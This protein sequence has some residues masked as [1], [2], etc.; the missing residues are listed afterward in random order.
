MV[1]SPLGSRWL[2]S[3]SFC[4]FQVGWQG[5][6]PKPCIRG[7]PL[8][9]WVLIQPSFFSHHDATNVNCW[10]PLH[11]EPIFPPAAC[12]EENNGTHIRSLWKAST[13]HTYSSFR[14]KNYWLSL[15]AKKFISNC[16]HLNREKLSISPHTESVYSFFASFSTIRRP[17]PVLLLAY[18]RWISLILSFF[19]GGGL[20]LHFFPV[21]LINLFFANNV[22]HHGSDLMCMRSIQDPMV[23]IFFS[24]ALDLIL[25]VPWVN[26]KK[27]SPGTAL[28]SD[29]SCLCSPP[30][31]PPS[32]A[33]APQTAPTP[34]LRLHFLQINIVTMFSLPHGIQ[35][36]GGMCIEGGRM[37]QRFQRAQSQ[38]GNA[39]HSKPKNV[40]FAD[41]CLLAARV[42]TQGGD[43][44]REKTWVGSLGLR[45]LKVFFWKFRTCTSFG[46]HPHILE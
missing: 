1:F 30:A 17:P 23:N 38:H 45:N 31:H 5:L 36:N 19:C 20:L 13:E 24:P 25:N 10:G 27:S 39:P 3:G 40:F 16:F 43:P 37:F 12:G 26:P 9:S 22:L 32:P 46:P 42:P 8:Q 6:I 41:E 18:F 34:S 33:E 29:N 44:G 4:W 2:T 7:L 14:H 15:H 11:L 21:S 28:F 35:W